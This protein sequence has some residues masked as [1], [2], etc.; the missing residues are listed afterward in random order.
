MTS[1][2]SVGSTPRKVFF[3][4]FEADGYHWMLLVFPCQSEEPGQRKESLSVYLELLDTGLLT[5][6]PTATVEVSAVSQHNPLASFTK[7]SLP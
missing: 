1:V 4:D 3:Q 6:L 2:P 5:V 7:V